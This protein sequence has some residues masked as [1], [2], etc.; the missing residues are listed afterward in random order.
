M[1]MKYK[2]NKINFKD[3]KKRKNKKKEK[4]IVFLYKQE[5]LIVLFH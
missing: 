1:I 4:T 2:C 5:V 3:Q